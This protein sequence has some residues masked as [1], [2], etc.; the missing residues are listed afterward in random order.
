M[1]ETKTT[2]ENG[3]SL[4]GPHVQ[5]ELELM[6]AGQKP[7]AQF[8]SEEGMDPEYSGIDFETYVEKGIFVKFTTPASPP[9]I[10]R[11]WYCLPGEEWRAK[12]SMLVAEK[13]A[14]K[15]IWANFSSIDLH[16]MD[17]FLLGYSKTCVE[18][19]VKVKCS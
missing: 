3:F 9:L 11:V 13:L 8:Y 10:E 6:L 4:I 5:R 19:F 15:S 7:M 16:R 17:G 12:L 1:S 18:H 2:D 14:D